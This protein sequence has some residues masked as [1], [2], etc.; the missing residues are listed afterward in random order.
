MRRLFF[1]FFY[2]AFLHYRQPVTLNHMDTARD[3]TPFNLHI[4]SFL[5]DA[6]VLP[7]PRGSGERPVRHLRPYDSRRTALRPR[8]AKW[9]PKAWSFGPP[10]EN[11]P[12]T[13]ADAITASLPLLPERGGGP[14]QALQGEPRGRGGACCGREG[15]TASPRQTRSRQGPRQPAAASQEG[16]LTSLGAVGGVTSPGL[17]YPA[18]RAACWK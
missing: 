16:L 15:G 17:H 9:L 18:G 1:F 12:R 14:A 5:R 4:A 6:T 7:Q 8:L 13:A 3:G 10:R 2:L 11:A